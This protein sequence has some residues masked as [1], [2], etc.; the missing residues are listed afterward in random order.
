MKNHTNVVSIKIVSGN[1]IWQV[2]KSKKHMGSGK[3]LALFLLPSSV[4]VLIYYPKFDYGFGDSML[5]WSSRK[6]MYQ[7]DVFNG[8]DDGQCEAVKTN[9]CTNIECFEPWRGSHNM[10]I[11]FT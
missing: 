11:D 10:Y 9:K 3:R 7:L 6:E 5:F 8:K 4:F 1:K 2:G